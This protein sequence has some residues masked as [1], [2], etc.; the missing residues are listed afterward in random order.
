MSEL[1]DIYDENHRHLGVKARAAVHRDGDWHRVFHCWVLWRDGQGGDWL[2]LQR[3]GAHKEI[4]PLHLAVTVGGHYQAGESVQDGLR[5]LREELGVTLPFEALVPCGTRSLVVRW[6]GLVDREFA[7]TFFLVSERPLMEYPV[8]RPEVAD[9]LA[10]K[11]EDAL[12]LVAGEQADV[13]AQSA[14]GQCRVAL[15]DLVPLPPASYAEV[16]LLARRVLDGERELVM[17]RELR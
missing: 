8:M 13:S 4:F 11:L 3:R 7:D 12:T 5:E 1:L 10:L 6:R 9:L 2:L 14:A 16:F 17:R 15:S